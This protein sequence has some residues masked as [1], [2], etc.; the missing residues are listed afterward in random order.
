MRRQKR[1]PR[2]AQSVAAAAPPACPDCGTQMI[3]VDPDSCWICFAP[4]VGGVSLNGVSY[5]LCE[6]HLE[7]IRAEFLAAAAPL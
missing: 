6:V 5:L 4:A 3:R 2:W 7:E 1:V